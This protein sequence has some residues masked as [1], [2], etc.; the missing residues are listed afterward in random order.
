MFEK[1][2]VGESIYIRKMEESDTEKIVE[3]RNSEAVRPHFIYQK[4]FTKESHLEWIHTMVNTG[5]VVQFIICSLD[6]DEPMGS[7]YIRDID[8]QHKKGEYGIFLAPTTMRGKGIGTQAARL[9]IEYGFSS[10]QLH[11]IFLRVFAENLQAIRSYEK[12]GFIKEAYLNDDVCID[13]KYKDM[14]L[15]AI[16]QKDGR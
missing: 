14:V 5:K 3:W 1:I 6:T 15:M 12:A 16:I 11:R 4:L 2:G 7:V 10:L 9:A 13:G 8:L